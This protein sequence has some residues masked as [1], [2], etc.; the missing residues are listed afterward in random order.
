MCVCV[1]W[2]GMAGS[3]RVLGVGLKSGTAGV[4]ADPS[5]SVLSATLWPGKYLLWGRRRKGLGSWPVIYGTWEGRG[6]RIH[7]SRSLE[8]NAGQG[9]TWGQWASPGGGRSEAEHSDVW[10]CAHC[11]SSHLHHHP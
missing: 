11:I 9:M 1:C 3:W 8:S 10:G 5:W 7:S 2:A 4:G 6:I